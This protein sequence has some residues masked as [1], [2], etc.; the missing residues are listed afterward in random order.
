MNSSGVYS[1]QY[2]MIQTEHKQEA[3]FA[4]KLTLLRKLHTWI[5]FLNW[6]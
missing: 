5:K 6:F 4:W 3:E 2:G 1:K